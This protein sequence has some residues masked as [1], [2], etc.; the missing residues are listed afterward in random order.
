MLMREPDNPVTAGDGNAP[1]ARRALIV[2]DVQ[3]DFCEGGALEVTG[4]NDVAASVAAFIDLH[5]DSYD[6]LAA[7]RDWHVDPGDHFAGPEGPDFETRWPPHCIAGTQ[8]AELHPLLARQRFDAIFDKGAFEAAYSGFEGRT[9]SGADLE[10]WLDNRHISRVD[11]CGLATDYCVRETALDAHR[12]GL[13]TRL[14]VDLAAGVSAERTR[15]AI[16]EMERAGVEV[17]DSGAA[18]AVIHG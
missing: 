15:T 3:N 18:T 2:V 12:S 9:R 5:G 14:L 16:A 13:D 6:A 1:E 4:G 11:I 8:G 17:I 7:T 10:S